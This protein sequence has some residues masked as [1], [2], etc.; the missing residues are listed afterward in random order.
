MA[1]ERDKGFS[2]QQIAEGLALGMLRRTPEG[3]IELTEKGVSALEEAAEKKWGPGAK[4][5]PSA[6]ERVENATNESQ[7][8]GAPKQEQPARRE[9][10]KGWRGWRRGSAGS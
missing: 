2:D 5:K 1:A 6:R 9:R 7:D 8:A 10:T 3:K 4:L